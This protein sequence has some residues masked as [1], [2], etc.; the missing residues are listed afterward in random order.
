M[1]ADPEKGRPTCLGICRPTLSGSA[2]AGGACM[3]RDLFGDVAV[4]PPSVRSRRSPVVVA[5]IA[6]H[7]A[8]VIAVLLATA[9]APDILPTPR[10]ALAFYEPTRLIDIELPPPPP[11]PRPRGVVAPP[12]VPRVSPDAAPVV[13]PTSISPE[14]WTPALERSS[15]VVNGVADGVGA[16]V[17]G[18]P[19]APP[20]PPVVTTPTKPVRMHGGIK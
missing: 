9:I 12:D 13:A 17:V 18:A 2:H 8:V 11:A 7:A 3:P 4:R 5:S 6:V 20:A 1:N 19:D 14:T 10:E 16:N 15:D